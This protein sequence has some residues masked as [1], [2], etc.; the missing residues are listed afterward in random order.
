MTTG[1]KRKLPAEVVTDPEILGGMPVIRG[2]RVPADT[3]AKMVE[4][5]CSNFDILRHYPSI[6]L[7]GIRAAVD[8]AKRHPR[9]AE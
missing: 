6:D 3:I 8:W 7:D 4:E 1:R 9:A 2:T 5:G